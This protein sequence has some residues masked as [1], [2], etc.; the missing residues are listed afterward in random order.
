MTHAVRSP[1]ASRLDPLRGRFLITDTLFKYHASCYLTH[2]AV[3]VA[4]RLR[5]GTDLRADDV[6]SVTVHGSAGCVGVCDISEPETGL[7]GKFSLRATTAMAL[8]GDD[9][10]DPAAFSDQRMRDPAFAAMRDRITFTPITELPPTRAMVTVQTA[11][12]ATLTEEADTGRPE[13]DLDRQWE[14]LTGKFMALATPIL[15]KAGSGR[16][17]DALADLEHAPTMREIAALARAASPVSA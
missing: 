15:G 6:A 7:Q 1:D 3:E 5:A 9:T 10:S 13:R 17:Y 12:G 4:T 8:L 16:L 11:A 14:L 2:A